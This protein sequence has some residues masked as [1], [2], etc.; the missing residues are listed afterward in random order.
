MNSDSSFVER[1]GE[2]RKEMLERCLSSCF[3]TLRKLQELV[4]KY[5]KLGLN[6]G[7]Q[8]WKKLK[9]VGKQE[10]ISR[11]KSKIMVHTTNISLCMTTIG[12]YVSPL[13]C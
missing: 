9:W 5:R 11:L 6:D 8:F 4:I 10:E 3:D 13:Q 2:N 12:K 1:L 7:I